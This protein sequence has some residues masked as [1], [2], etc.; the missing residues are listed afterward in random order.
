M[1]I[2]RIRLS[3]ARNDRIISPEGNPV[4]VRVMRTDEKLM[5][6]RHTCKLLVKESTDERDQGF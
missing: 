2:L 6:A 5:I 3:Q 4:T 1:E